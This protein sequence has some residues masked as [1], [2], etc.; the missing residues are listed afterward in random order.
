MKFI[1]SLT[2]AIL[3]LLAKTSNGRSLQRTIRAP[4]LP[5]NKFNLGMIDTCTTPELSIC[6]DYVDYQIPG[7]LAEPR[8]VAIKESVISAAYN[9]TASQLQDGHNSTLCAQAF[10]EL[11]CRNQFPR[12]TQDAQGV[13]SVVFSDAGCDKL[14]NQCS[15]TQAARFVTEGY[16]SLNTTVPLGQCKHTSEYTGY[17]FCNGVSGWQDWYIT[18]W[19]HLYLRRN[20][21][22]ISAFKTAGFGAINPQCIPKFVE[23][24]CTSVGRCWDQGRQ[25]E[26]IPSRKD[27]NDLVNW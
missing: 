4:D 2:A 1:V 3:L 20:E 9:I 6:R 27:C 10:L 23:F 17:E 16:C 18:D 7:V 22:Q 25:A 5:I 19:M 8:F 24:S 11:E 14:T 15:D 21:D 13:L 12:C 26:L